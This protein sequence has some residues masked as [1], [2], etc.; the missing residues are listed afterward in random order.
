[1]QKKNNRGRNGLNFNGEPFFI[2]MAEQFTIPILLEDTVFLLSLFAYS[3]TKS[4]TNI[5]VNI[6]LKSVL[7]SSELFEY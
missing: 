6:R 1:M 3:K 2:I 4:N 7:F 5:S